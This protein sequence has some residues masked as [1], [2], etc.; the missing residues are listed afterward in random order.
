MAGSA[1]VWTVPLLLLLLPNPMPVMLMFY[2][3]MGSDS[4]GGVVPVAAGGAVAAAAA[5]VANAAAVP[6]SWPW[7]AAAKQTFGAGSA[8]WVHVTSS[9]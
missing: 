1:A 8:M 5:V 3:R 6:D 9:A 2:T 7:A 4:C